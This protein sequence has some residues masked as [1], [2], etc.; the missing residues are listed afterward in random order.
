M[1]EVLKPGLETSVQD[2]PGRIGFW[3]QGFPPSGP[4]DSWSF[5]LANLVVGNEPGEAALECQFLGPTLRFERAT[6][7]AVTGAEMAPTLDGRRIPMWE[8]LAVHPGQTLALGAVRVGARAYLAFA[9]GVAVPA[10]MG[11]RSTFHMAGVGGVDGYAL[12][13]GQRVPLGEGNGVAGRRVRAQCRPPIDGRHRWHVEVVPGPND[14][15]I[16][17][18]GQRRFFASD[19]KVSA[20]SN[21]TGFRLDGPEWSFT[22][23]ATHKRPEHGRDPSNILDHGYPIGAINLAGQTPIILV[24]DAPSTGGFINP[25]TVATA[26][27]WKL[28]QAVPADILN[29]AAVTVAEA[30]ELRR[31]LDRLCRPESLE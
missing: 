13:P 31:K 1:F 7:I 28:A 8:S 22:A 14:D 12:K 4:M 5:R 20:K 9:G 29:F 17:E 15:W 27:F 3:E 19:W 2:L 21:R 11:S 30:Q 16:D 25:Y 6:V 23:K 26:S 10:V 24:N 18:A